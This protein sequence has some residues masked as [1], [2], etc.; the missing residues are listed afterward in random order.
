ME[1]K[2]ASSFGASP[3]IGALGLATLLLLSCPAL[4]GKVG[5]MLVAFGRG[6]CV[7]Q[8]CDRTSAAE[9]RFAGFRDRRESRRSDPTVVRIGNLERIREPVA[10]AL[11]GRRRAR[12]L[13]RRRKPGQVS[14]VGRPQSSKI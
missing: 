2:S 7:N 4:E 9:G 13:G 6:S 1:L 14:S 12:A 11:D 5:N 8:G 10:W 3:L